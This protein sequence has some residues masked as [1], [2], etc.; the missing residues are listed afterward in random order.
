VLLIREIQRCF[1]D[2]NLRGRPDQSWIHRVNHRQE[3]INLRLCVRCPFEIVS[4][5]LGKM[6]AV[7]E[8]KKPVERVVLGI[9]RKRISP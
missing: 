5:A 8:G 1:F 6:L 2:N 9:T 7:P 4:D 3:K